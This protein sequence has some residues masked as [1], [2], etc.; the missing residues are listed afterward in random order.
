MDFLPSPILI[1]F[2]IL[3]KEIIMGY[4]EEELYKK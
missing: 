4:K 2:N 3:E 1:I